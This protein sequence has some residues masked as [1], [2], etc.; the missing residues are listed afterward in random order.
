[1]ENHKKGIILF[2][3]HFKIFHSGSVSVPALI[4]RGLCQLCAIEG[5]LLFEGKYFKY[6][7]EFII[8]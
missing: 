3:P 8:E 7:H 2:N 1:M 4:A 5:H 6:F